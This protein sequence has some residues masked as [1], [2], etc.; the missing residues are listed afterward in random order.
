MAGQHKFPI[1]GPDAVTD[2]PCASRVEKEN[3]KCDTAYPRCSV[4]QQ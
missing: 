1:G 2:E 4:D 3:D